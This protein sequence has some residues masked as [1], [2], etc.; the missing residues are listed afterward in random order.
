MDHNLLIT[1]RATGADKAFIFS[2]W[3]KSYRTTM[4]DV[5]AALYYAGQH[6]I[7]D[8]ILGQ[9]DAQVLASREDEA[10]VIGWIV[11]SDQWI[12]YLY[13]KQQFRRMGLARV[14]VDDPERWLGYSHKVR[15][16]RQLPLPKTW[17]FNPYQ[18]LQPL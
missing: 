5:P 14:L 8:R 3:L 9:C 12:H 15:L 7:I 17:A 2:S 16:L 13:I 11:T 18:A 1:R 6:D 4:G 10:T